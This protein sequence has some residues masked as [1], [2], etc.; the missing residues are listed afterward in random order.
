[1]R[2]FHIDYNSSNSSSK[3][4]TRSGASLFVRP[5]VRPFIWLGSFFSESLSQLLV[6]HL[7][8]YLPG[9]QEESGGTDTTIPSVRN[10]RAK[11]RTTRRRRR[12]Q[13]TNIYICAMRTTRCARNTCSR[14]R[15]VFDGS[16]RSLRRP[17]DSLQGFRISVFF[18]FILF[19]K[20]L[21][22]YI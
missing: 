2:K 11:N 13:R 7:L 16:Q 5:S 9:R 21:Y 14:L 22:L 8:T 19:S 15:H 3:S 12:S 17:S 10:V 18:V 4:R 20:N 1:M 6:G